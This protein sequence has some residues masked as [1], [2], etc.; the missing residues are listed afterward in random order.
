MTNQRTEWTCPKCKATNDPDFTHC[1]MCGT[2]N[3]DAP[4]PKKKCSSCGFLANEEK[5]CPVCG[6][7]YFLQL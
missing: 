7:D 3:P 2:H 1:R 4:E 6:S 5:C